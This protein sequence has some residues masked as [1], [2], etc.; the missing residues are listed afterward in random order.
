MRGVSQTWQTGVPGG[1]VAANTTIRGVNGSCLAPAALS[2][3]NVW[4]RWLSNGDVALLLI[5]FGPAPAAVSCDAACMAALAAPRLVPPPVAWSARDV[6][7]QQPAGTITQAEGY[8][9]PLL[10]SEG[11]SILLRLSPGRA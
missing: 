2:T 11:G 7:L 5:N 10:P 3:F 1:G 6:W 8:T 9:S 4:A